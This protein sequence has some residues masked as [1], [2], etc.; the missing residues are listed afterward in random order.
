[1]NSKGGGGGR[2]GGR[3]GGAPQ[4]ETDFAQEIIAVD[5]VTRVMAGGKRMRFRAC[6]AIG[7]PQGHRVGVGIAKGADVTGAVNKAVTQARKHLVAVPVYRESIPCP[8]EV[9]YKGAHILLKPAPAGTGVKVGGA[10]RTMLKLAQ[11]SN[12]VGKNLGSSNKISNVRAT[13]EA[14]RR[15]QQL[16]RPAE[17]EL[18][19]ET[20]V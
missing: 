18:S 7:M 14:F 11:V 9:K 5:R 2:R 1:M 4:P 17:T 3:G 12:V 6:V 10:V 13:L 8:V 16:P 19:T 20:S 15:L